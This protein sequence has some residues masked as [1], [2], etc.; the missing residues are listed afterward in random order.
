MRL[1]VALDLPWSVRERLADLAGG[2]AGARWVP[3]ENYHINLRFIG[4]TPNH[5]AEEI[6]LALAAVRARGFN[7]EI[8]GFGSFER[9]GRPTTLWARVAPNPLLEHLQGKVDTALRRA[10]LDAERRRF[11]PHITLARVDHVTPA[12]LAAWVAAHNLMRSSPVE[13]QHF[14][15][16]SSALGKEQSVYTPEVDYA[17]AAAA[18]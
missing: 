10:G 14:T 15:L 8:A 11:C 1:F 9:Q 2:L 7:V 5:V 12:A 16:F 6:D 17:L 3:P 13:V 4:E 18:I